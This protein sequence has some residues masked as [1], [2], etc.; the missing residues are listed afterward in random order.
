M[1]FSS[2]S[3]WYVPVW[4]RVADK[5]LSVRRSFDMQRG[6]YRTR[7]T[8]LA[9]GGTS[10]LQTVSTPWCRI[11]RSG[12]GVHSSTMPRSGREPRDDES[13]DEIDE[14]RRLIVL[15]GFVVHPHIIEGVFPTHDNILNYS[16]RQT[17]ILVRDPLRFIPC[18]SKGKY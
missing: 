7:Y 8:H 15:G 10:G 12:T 18:R 4:T 16:S 3:T 5:Q 2:Y 9:T 6:S 17:R 1:V 14:R 13:N 11:L